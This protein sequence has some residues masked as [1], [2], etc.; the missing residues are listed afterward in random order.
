MNTDIFKNDEIED[1]YS[2]HTEN[3]EISR[4]KAVGD[5]IIKI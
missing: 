2:E 4:E 5:R 3:S 1:D